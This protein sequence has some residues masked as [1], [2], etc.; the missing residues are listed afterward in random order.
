MTTSDLPVQPK[1]AYVWI[2]LPG[3]TEPVVAGRLVLQSDGVLS[4]NY[5]Q[6]YLARRDAIPIYLPELP[7]ERGVQRPHDGLHMA[8]CLRDGSPDAWGRRVIINRMMGV[9]GNAADEVQLN[10]L[11]FLLHSSSNRVG[12]LDFQAT[13]KEYS[14]RQAKPAPLKELLEAAA[15]VEAGL[16]IAP[17]LNEALSHGTSIGGA[18]PKA[19]IE[20]AD[21]QYIAKFS[22]SNDTYSVVKA[23]FIAMSIARLSGLSVAPV[24]SECSAGKDVLLVERFDRVPTNGG[25]ARKAMVSGLT[26]L[27]LDEMMARYAS[28]ADLADL[29]RERFVEPKKTLH[30]LFGRIACNIL[31]GNTDDHARNHAAFWDGEMLTLT[32]AYDICPQART[33]REASQAMLIHGDDRR[34]Q[35]ATLL[36]ASQVFGYRRKEAGKVI[37]GLIDTIRMHWKD[38]CDQAKVTKIDRTFFIGRQFLNAY[39][40]DDLDGDNARLAKM[41]ADTRLEIG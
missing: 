1:E 8:N 15:K 21:R 27:G 18:R 17:E 16:P 12:A 19:A 2:W 36:N 40:F 37:G 41:A 39:A 26:I 9:K 24:R 7:L 20:D 13:P 34:S 33:G 3:A 23:E 25:V 35:I 14:P 22:S 38:L 10:E 32:P 5:G 29:I 28:Y 30:E 11:A 31:C 6:S 4:F